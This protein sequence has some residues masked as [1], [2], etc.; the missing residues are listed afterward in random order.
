MTWGACIHRERS[1]VRGLRIVYESREETRAHKYELE[2]WH[3]TQFIR[4]VTDIRV[5]TIIMS[6]FL[7]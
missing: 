3:V 2:L 1:R 4:I 5:F 7:L 6:D